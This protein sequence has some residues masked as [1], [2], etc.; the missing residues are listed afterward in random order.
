MTDP[1]RLPQPESGAVLLGLRPPQLAVLTIAALAALAVL[2]AMANTTGLAIAGLLLAG[3]GAFIA[4]RPAGRPIDHWARIALRWYAGG[5]RTWRAPRPAGGP[6]PP[7]AGTS[8][9]QVT[10]TD[11][12]QPIGI[13]HQQRQGRLTALITF[14]GQPAA[15]TAP[16]TLHAHSEAWAAILD[17]LAAAN[18][19][20]TWLHTTRQ[21]TIDEIAPDLHDIDP[22]DPLWAAYHDLAADLAPDTRTH[23]SHLALSLTADRRQLPDAIEQLV[24]TALDLTARLPSAG[25]VAHQICDRATL[26]QQYAERFHPPD[27]T[28]TVAGTGPWP[29][30]TEQR[31]ATYRTDNAIH[32]TFDIHDWPHHPVTPGF[33]D[34]LL[35]AAPA[36]TRLSFAL[37]HDPI[38]PAASQRQVRAARAEHVADDDLRQQ[39]GL[40]DSATRS[41]RHQDLV[42][43]ETE[44]AGGHHEFRYHGTLTVTAAHPEQLD[45]AA[46]QL[47]EHAAAINLQ[48]T[49]SYGRQAAAFAASLP[50]GTHPT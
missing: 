31:W 30:A 48:L 6:P 38:P 4:A 17:S 49:R 13:I 26:S 28:P 40:L 34:S 50:G 16:D 15:S 29:V 27:T 47:T 12:P 45:T 22:T 42:Q 39:G 23:H 32:T 44:L 36:G 2:L 20:L 11:H 1:V 3:A 43:R 37:H 35:T 46:R 10:H 18:V 14:T 5:A 21:A 25:L 8:L 24:D 41:H 7:L 33:L 9:L 19:R